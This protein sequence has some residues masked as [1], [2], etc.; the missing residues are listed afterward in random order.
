MKN[1]CLGCVIAWLLGSSVF[2]SGEPTPDDVRAR[3]RLAR[4]KLEAIWDSPAKYTFKHTINRWDIPS[5]MVGKVKLGDSFQFDVFGQKGRWRIDTTIDKENGSAFKNVVVSAQGNRFKI[6]QAPGEKVF[7]DTKSDAQSRLFD[8]SL[9]TVMG[10]CEVAFVLPTRVD[11][12]EILF[13]PNYRLTV[14][15]NS[16]APA[17][18]EDR[19]QAGSLMCEFV[20]SPKSNPATKSRGLVYEMGRITFLPSRDWAIDHYSLTTNTGIHFDGHVEYQQLAGVASQTVPKRVEFTS[21]ESKSSLKTRDVLEAVSIIPGPIDDR[22]FQLSEFQLKSL[23]VKQ[24][25]GWSF[26]TILIVLGVQLIVI[27]IVI[28]FLSTR[29]SRSPI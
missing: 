13:G 16:D 5:E 18:A 20:R 7:S 27:A 15:A 12:E 1:F 8:E 4:P 22:V 21:T 25:E 3:Y 23:D 29:K 28:R 19:G 11:V 2:A 26:T 10:L 14:V 9:K 6:V 17:G 24:S